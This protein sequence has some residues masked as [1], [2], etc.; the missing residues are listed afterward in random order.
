MPGADPDRDGRTNAA[1]LMQGT[2]PNDP[3][4]AGPFTVIADAS[5]LHLEFTID[6][7]L[8]VVVNG[9]HL[10]LS[11]GGGGAP[12]R[13]TGQTQPGLAGVWNSAPPH[14]PNA[15]ARPT[16]ASH[17]CHRPAPRRQSPPW[18]R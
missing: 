15:N 3:A 14:H 6:S 17:A 12:L 7:T 1:E 4:D 13:L 18:R 2:D 5:H 10:E 9:S 11:D 8:S 16:R